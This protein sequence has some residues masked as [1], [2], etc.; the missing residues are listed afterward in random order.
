MTHLSTLE[1][2]VAVVV[3]MEKE[4]DKQ[5][6]VVMEEIETMVHKVVVLEVQ[7]EVVVEQQVAMDLV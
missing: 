2:M 6:M 7:T 4:E 5:E 3:H 1:V